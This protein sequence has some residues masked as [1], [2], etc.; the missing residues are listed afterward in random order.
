MRSPLAAGVGGVAAAFLGALCCAGPLLFV[1]FGVGAGLASAFEPLRPLFTVAMAGFLGFGFY[2]VYGRP[3]GKR[4]G[5]AVDA[6]GA[7]CSVSGHRAGDRVLIWCAAALA[8]LIWS[9]PYWL[10]LFV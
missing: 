1:F 3:V 8:A 7:S 10:E 4:S 6:A 9:L 2:V 5:S